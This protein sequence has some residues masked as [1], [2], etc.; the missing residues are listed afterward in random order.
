MRFVA[1]RFRLS[2]AAGISFTVLLDFVA[3]ARS[4]GINSS[5]IPLAMIVQVGEFWYIAV[6]MVAIVAFL[7]TLRYFAALSYFLLLS[8]LLLACVVIE[9]LAVPVLPYG[10]GPL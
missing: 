2:V 10:C 3:A 4:C 9:V 8:L 6:A 1:D 5:E 7:G